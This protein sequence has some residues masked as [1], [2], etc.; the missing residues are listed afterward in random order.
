MIVYR[1]GYISQI[2]SIFRHGFSRQFLAS[3]EGTDYGD[4][5]YCN[6]D[7]NDSKERLRYT[8]G[9]CL[10]KCE[11]RGGLDRYLIFNEHY[12]RKT[13]GANYSIKD[14]VYLLFGEDAN[15]VWRDFTN[16]MNANY[17][18]REHMHGR[19]AELLQVLLSPRRLHK[20]KEALPQSD[21][22][23]NVRREYEILFKK[24]NI[25]GAIY[26]GMK[27]GLCLVAYDFGECVP[28]EYSKDGGR[29]WIKKEFNGSKTDVEKEFGL[30]YKSISEPISIND[31]NG[32]HYFSKVQKKNGKYNYINAESGE[33][34]S[35]IDFDSVTLMNPQDGI[36]Q[37]EYKGKFL[38][39]CIYGFFIDEEH[40][41]GLTFDELDEYLKTEKVM[42]LDIIDE[43]ELKFETILENAIKDVYARFTSQKPIINESLIGENSMEEVKYGDYDIPSLSDLD[44]PN[45]VSIYHVTHRNVVDSIFKHEF[46]RE[47]NCKNGNVYGA[48]VYTTINI[49]DSRTLLG[50]FYGDAMIQLKLIGGFDRFLI[51]QEDLARKYYG[52]NW[53]IRNQ[54]RTMMPKEEA[55]KLYERNRLDVRDY[56][57]VAN[58]YNIRG[59]IYPWQ[60]V[61][62]V[63]PFDFSTVIPYAVSYDGGKTFQKKVSQD[64]IN[65]T[66]TSVDVEYRYGHKY[67]R[68]DK[69]IAGYN[70]DRELT[71][72][73]R[74]QKRNGKWNYI[75]IQNGQE[76][77]PIDFDSVTLMNPTSMDEENPNH[78]EGYFQLSFKNRRGKEYFFTACIYG[79]FIDE[80]LEEGLTF[81]ELPE[82]VEKLN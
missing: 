79:F 33:E 31:E 5:V 3:N 35:P 45:Y 7:I 11:I 67:R 82:Y 32:I 54:L 42:N 46:D 58:K 29:T 57:K 66:I 47:F 68:I 24:H 50:S 30:K 22:H 17:S 48:G 13:Y 60:G 18:A 76:V 56:S 38:D 25:R 27:D 15:K 77:S 36:F 75:D 65:R 8:S 64:T 59:A 70:E 2:E 78:N 23:R 49:Q 80:E 72:F 69:A 39:A 52:E 16:I 28:I 12:A 51:F 1:V 26:K 71:G 44:S 37:I 53:T 63:L 4:G 40:E 6:I 19:T 14:Q 61:T 9:G 43:Q 10:L 34:I 74:V 41:N 20:L 55:D 73:A 21:R 81:D 62:A